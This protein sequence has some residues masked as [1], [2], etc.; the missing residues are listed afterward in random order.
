[1]LYVQLG[2][3][4]FIGIQLLYTLRAW[5]IL[6]AVLT[7]TEYFDFNFSCGLLPRHVSTCCRGFPRPALGILTLLLNLGNSLSPASVS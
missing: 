7:D 6:K 5:H 3:T 1:M 2:L 4:H